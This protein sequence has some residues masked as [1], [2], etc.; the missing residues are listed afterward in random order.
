MERKEERASEKG[1]WEEREEG[2][3][4]KREGGRGSTDSSSSTDGGGFLPRPVVAYVILG[5]AA[6]RIVVEGVSAPQQESV[7]PHQLELIHNVC[8]FLRIRES[9]ACACA[10]S[11]PSTGLD[12]APIRIL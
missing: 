10:Q 1:R 7:A 3:E 8:R 4:R 12:R 6:S 11:P 9:F 5:V 2:R